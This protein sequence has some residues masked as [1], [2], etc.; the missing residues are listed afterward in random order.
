MGWSSFQ[1]IRSDY[2]DTFK[3]I[4]ENLLKLL[5]ERKELA[6][7]KNAF[8]P[9]SLMQ[10]WSE[11]YKLDIPQISWLIHS[12]NSRSSFMILDGPNELLAVIPIM[13]KSIV[14]DFEYI[15][16]HSMQ[17]QNCSMIYLEIKHTNKEEHVDHILPQLMLLI[18]GPVSF[19]VSHHGAHG[20]GG[21]AKIS[22][23]I[24]PSLPNNLDNISF[25]LIPHASPMDSSLKEVKLNKEVYF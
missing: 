8:P 13:K 3:Q 22:F 11:K 14:G 15:L 23:L 20:G 2:N 4:D 16:T 9:E 5:T 25:A 24:Y 1:K 12:L 18:D 6:N 10:E 21:E 19:D 17:H 7:G